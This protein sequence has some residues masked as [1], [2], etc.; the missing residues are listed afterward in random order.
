MFTAVHPTATTTTPPTPR[1][2]RRVL[3]SGAVALVLAATLAGC[4]GGGAAAPTP[5]ATVPT[6]VAPTASAAPTPSASPTPTALASAGVDFSSIDLTVPPPRPDALDAP[7][8]K[9]AAAHVAEYFLLLLPYAAVTH[10]LDAFE[11]LAYAD[12]R[13]CNQ[14]ITTLEEYEANDIVTDGGGII[15]ADVEV[16]ERDAEFFT[17]TIT[18]TQ[19]PSR[20]TAPDGSVIDEGIGGRMSHEIDLLYDDGAW[21]VTSWVEAS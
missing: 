7:P 3:A 21:L 15:V 10:D 14:V 17:A 6:T 16:E 13:Y 11:K 9:Q 19:A 18:F 1:P 4:T 12:C 5:S 2:A 20:E 8:S